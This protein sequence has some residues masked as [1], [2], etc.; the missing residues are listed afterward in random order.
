MKILDDYEDD[1]EPQVFRRAIEYFRERR[2]S[3]K[4]ADG[5]TLT[6]SAIGSGENSYVVRL[7]IHPNGTFS[8]NC[9]CPYDWD[10]YCKH[11]GAAILTGLAMDLLTV[12]DDYLRDRIDLHKTFNA[13]P[14]LELAN[15]QALE[16]VVIEL[17]S[18]LVIEGRA[19]SS[20]L[21][22]L[23]AIRDPDQS[24]P[25]PKYRLVFV[26]V[27][28]YEY[29]HS[30]VEPLEI[31]PSVR[32]M[33]KDGTPGRFLQYT[34]K[35]SNAE[36][37]APAAQLL[38]MYHTDGSLP[39]STILRFLE[40]HPQLELYRQIGN[41]HVR[42]KLVPANHAILTFR[43][44]AIEGDDIPLYSPA[45]D[46]REDRESEEEDAIPAEDLEAHTSGTVT[47]FYTHYSPVVWYSTGRNDGLRQLLL[48]TGK[49]PYFSPYEIAKLTQT[50]DPGFFTIRPPAGSIRLT[51]TH[52]TVSL[53]LSPVSEGTLI[54]FMIGYGS[55]EIDVSEDA[56][57]VIEE[58]H[59]GELY[60]YRRD[61]QAEDDIFSGIADLLEEQL[62]HPSGFLHPY[63]LVRFLGVLG[64]SL[65][66]LGCKLFTKEGKRPINQVRKI[67]IVAASG[68]D[69]L[70]LEVKLDGQRISRRQLFP[71]DGLIET[72]SGF[73][74]LDGE[75]LREAK[76]LINLTESNLDKFLINRFDLHAIADIG[77]LVNADYDDDHRRLVEAAH[78]VQDGFRPV[79]MPAGMKGELR[80]YQM[81]GLSWLEFLRE[82][83]FGGILA[84]DM[85]LGKTIQAIA[86]IALYANEE[87][88]RYL[89]VAPVST[90]SNWIRELKTFLPS[91]PAW[92]H[93][94]PERSSVPITDKTG[95]V[96]TSYHTL[97]RDVEM[98]TAIEWDLLVIDES[99]QLKN[100]RSKSHKAVRELTRK[101]TL[102]M[103]G[104]PVENNI[105]ELWSIMHILNPG[106]LRGRSGFIGRFRKP[107]SE[108][109]PDAAQ[110]L[111]R[112]VDPFILRRT[113]EMVATDLPPKEEVYVPVTLSSAEL[114]YYLRTKEQL[115]E[116]VLALIRSDTPFKAAT[117]IVRAL[118]KL[119]QAAIAPV[120]LGG[121]DNSSKIDT[122]M[123]KVAEGLAEGHKILL[124]S[125]FVRVLRLIEGQLDNSGQEYLY[126][127]GS[128]SPAKRKQLIDSFQ[129]SDG[130]RLFLISLK[131]GGVGINLT[132]ADYVF[133]VDPWWNPAV[134]Q[135]AVDRTHRIGQTKPVFAYRFISE[136]TIEEQILDLQEKKKELVRSIIGEDASIFKTL[137]QDEIVA[138]FE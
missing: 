32:Y 120:L 82:Y 27:D 13:A 19:S 48:L 104:T 131:A 85:G 121:P 15:P 7:F 79:V 122:V 35:Y 133:I 116:E 138:L 125:Q 59:D 118:T 75:G 123:D 8:A 47:Y 23:S 99:Q 132:E 44:R 49:T 90:V 42:V 62:W 117:A 46:I 86:L 136:G 137:T 70:E 17:K 129:Q 50:A 134:E 12:E 64:N 76:Q 20:V 100:H 107:L 101:Q 51:S 66:S 95:V 124:F 98:F 26:I 18:D 10:L 77:K 110:N 60:V 128:T 106:L 72:P 16:D 37:S 130:A 58:E 67:S 69:W 89:V 93:I 57:L 96:V 108:G 71:E 9:T 135:Q 25:D 83:G 38:D 2:L 3:L 65:V 88:G 6:F 61:S 105:G 114:V 11:V 74:Y 40:S 34:G 24:K 4:S 126:L 92:A 1:F 33:R 84:D 55:R 53:Y 91:V 73:V 36:A 111:K 119:R 97:Q 52:P 29:Y 28:L 102:A 14:A 81:A 103:S 113:K 5:N 54:Q 41:V 31:T 112:M 45:M 94:G 39:F 63:E 78:R 56:P 22:A 43:L 115:R 87:T 30:P 21:P 80:P 127:D 109:D 68:I